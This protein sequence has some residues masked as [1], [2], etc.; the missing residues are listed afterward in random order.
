M[1]LHESINLWSVAGTVLILGFMVIVGIAKMQ[2]A[3]EKIHEVVAGEPEELALLFSAERDVKQ[4]YD[5]VER[6]VRQNCDSAQ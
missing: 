4:D 5:S 3:D 2:V 1:F 6:G